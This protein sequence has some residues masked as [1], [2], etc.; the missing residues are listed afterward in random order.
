MKG[1]ELLPFGPVVQY[2][3]PGGDT[4]VEPETGGLVATLAALTQE[5]PFFSFPFLPPFFLALPSFMSLYLFSHIYL[6]LF[7]SP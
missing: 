7:L 3:G 5:H 6:L 1:E 2:P 4:G